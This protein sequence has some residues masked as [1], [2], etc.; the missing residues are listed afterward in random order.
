[1]ALNVKD[2]K[3]QRSLTAAYTCNNC[4]DCKETVCRS[5][6]KRS[7][8]NELEPCTISNQQCLQQRMSVLTKA[9]NM[10]IGASNR[11]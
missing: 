2:Q 10:L 1:M 6:D 4:F 3:L 8:E 11:P 7:L 5:A 9:I